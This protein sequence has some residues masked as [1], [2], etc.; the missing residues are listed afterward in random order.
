[1]TCNPVVVFSDTLAYH[2]L[3]LME[4][5]RSQ[6]SVLPFVDQERRCV[7]LIRLHDIVKSGL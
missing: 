2:A 7:G 5:R 3:Q 6:I 4:D 1:M